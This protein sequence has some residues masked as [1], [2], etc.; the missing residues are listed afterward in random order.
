MSDLNKINLSN[1]EPTP[2]IEYTPSDIDEYEV[3]VLL[4]E[5]WEEI[6]NYIINENEID[7]IPNRKIP[8]L[9]IRL[10]NTKT[11]IKV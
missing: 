6:H 3:V 9:I 7:G 5:Y 10:Q 8:C 11:F 2:I 1:I 4:P